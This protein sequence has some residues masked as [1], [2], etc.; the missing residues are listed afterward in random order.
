MSIAAARGRILDAGEREEP[1]NTSTV[2]RGYSFK[3]GFGLPFWRT[4]VF[5]VIGALYVTSL[6][7]PALREALAKVFSYFP[8]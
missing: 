3:D 1:M 5:G 4:V 6:F 2:S 8:R 7:V